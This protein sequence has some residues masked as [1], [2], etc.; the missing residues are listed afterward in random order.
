MSAAP[1][2]SISPLLAT[3]IA[4][5]RDG[6]AGLR[7]AVARRQAARMNARSPGGV[8]VLPGAV[9]ADADAAR[10]Q[11][12]DIAEDFDPDF[13]RMLRDELAAEIAEENTKRGGR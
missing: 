6:G 8:I 7:E 4:G 13:L 1:G 11:A 9:N 3:F 2:Q 5:L 10:Q 12:E